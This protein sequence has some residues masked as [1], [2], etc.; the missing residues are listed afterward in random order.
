MNFL[1]FEKPIGELIEL[2]DKMISTA[3]KSKVDVS[4]S[5]VEIEE[6]IVAKRKEIYGNLTPWQRVQV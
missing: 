2:R 3:E 5:L 6:K 1:D 4:K